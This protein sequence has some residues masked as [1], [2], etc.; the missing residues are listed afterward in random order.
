MTSEIRPIKL[1]DLVQTLASTMV[2]T[3]QY[4]DRATVDLQNLYAGSASNALAALTP[5]RFTID[6]VTIDLTFVI[7][8]AGEGGLR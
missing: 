1:K 2:V 3:T 6:E 5:P 4:L 7:E 8:D